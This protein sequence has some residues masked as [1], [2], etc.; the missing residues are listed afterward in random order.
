MRI[1]TSIIAVLLLAV[2]GWLAFNWTVNRI[3]VPEGYSLQLFY[4]GPLVGTPQQAE[5]GKWAQEHQVGVR[6]RL[7]GPGRHFYCP[8]WWQRKLVPDVLIMPGEIGIVTCKIGDSLPSGEF[9]VDGAIGETT[10]KGILRQTL[11][12]GRFRINP[13]GY[14]VKVIS[15]QVGATASLDKHSG[16]VS[17][18]TGFVGVVTNLAANPRLGIAKGIQQDVLPPGLYMINGRERKVNIVEIGYRETT[19]AHKKLRDSNGELAM[20]DAGE[21]MIQTDTDGIDFPSSDGF[22]IQ[23]DFT[24][25]WGIM[26]DQAANAVRKFGNVDAVEDKVVQPQVESICRNNGSKYSAVQLLVGKDREKFQQQNLDEFH[27]V[28][29]EKQITLLYGLVRHI[30][31]PRQVRVPIQSAFVADEMTLTRAQEQETAKIEGLFREAE[32]NVELEKE[33]VIVDTERQFQSRLADGDRQAKGID[34]ETQRLAAQIGKDTAKLKAQAVTL[35]GEAENK[36][37][38]EIEEAKADRFRLAVDAFG[39]P[40]A[41][42]NWIFATGLPT[43]IELKLIYAGEGTLWTNLNDVGIRAMVP[44]KQD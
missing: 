13:Y 37:K 35:L 7:C 34:A 1:I 44:L 42:N 39:T 25:I 32:Q 20:D 43:D 16:W 5:T 6:E 31:I 24:A 21:P 36:G 29:N 38:K 3:Y 15:K 26:P 19:L 18:P 11:P 8:V 14:E 30:Y 2:G 28:L 40:E 41:Y 33:K 9:L 22:P 10:E 12:P 27:E 17:I 4:K 23:M